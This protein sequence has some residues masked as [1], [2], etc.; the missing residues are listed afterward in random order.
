[1]Q[2]ASSR[3]GSPFVAK[4]VNVDD[5]VTELSLNSAPQKVNGTN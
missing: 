1:M 2:F 5:N 3:P 4:P